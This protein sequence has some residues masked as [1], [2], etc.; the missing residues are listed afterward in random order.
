MND[1]HLICCCLWSISGHLSVLSEMDWWADLYSTAWCWE[2]IRSLLFILFIDSLLHHTAAS[3]KSGSALKKK[4]V[5]QVPDLHWSP[6]FLCCVSKQVLSSLIFLLTSGRQL[7]DKSDLCF[8]HAWLHI[9]LQAS[10]SD[11]R[12][13]VLHSSLIHFLLHFSEWEISVFLFSSQ[14]TSHSSHVLELLMRTAANAPPA[15]SEAVQNPLP[16]T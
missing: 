8:G 6:K 4:V 1:N 11:L 15:Q 14:Y 12:F 13:P 16:S 10:N 7:N 5:P 3:Q 9:A 2:S